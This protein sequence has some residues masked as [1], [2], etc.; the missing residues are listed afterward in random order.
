MK[1]TLHGAEKI[2]DRLF[3]GD[4]LLLNK[5]VANLATRQLQSLQDNWEPFKNYINILQEKQN[6]QLW[7]CFHKMF[8]FFQ[9]DGI[10]GSKTLWSLL[11]CTIHDNGHKLNASWR[12]RH[13][14]PTV[15][16]WWCWLRLTHIYLVPA[17]LELSVYITEHLIT[18]LQVHHCWKNWQ[19][20]SLTCFCCCSAKSHFLMHMSRD[21][22]NSKSPIRHSDWMPS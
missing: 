13:S 18:A 16:A 12:S 5:I 4:T 1:P 10:F 9:A 14:G 7:H 6:S 19:Q 3:T 17:W 2:L 11:W 15:G 20:W 21:P 8:N 22:V